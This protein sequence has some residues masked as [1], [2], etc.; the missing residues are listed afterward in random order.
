MKRNPSLTPLAVL[1]LGA[2]CHC[3]HTSSPGIIEAARNLPGRGSVQ[4]S[5]AEIPRAPVPAQ[6]SATSA[7]GGAV[8]ISVGAPVATDAALHPL[9]LGVISGPD[10]AASV[11]RGAD[12][13]EGY[14]QIGVVSVRNND[15]YDDRLDFAGILDC[16]AATAP[17][18]DGCDPAKDSSYRW[19]ASDRQY[20]SYLDG[21][22][23]PFLRLG[24]E[25]QNPSR[26]HA[27]ASPKNRQQEDALVEAARRITARYK[28]W[29]AHPRAFEYLDIWTEFPGQHFWSGNPAAF[30]P[31]WIRMYQALDA[32][33]PE[34][35]IGG[36]GFAMP[37]TMQ[38]L[39]GR[40]GTLAEQ[41]LS[42][43]YS[44]K[45][46]PDWFGWHIFSSSPQEYARAAA[47][48]QDL[49]DGRG[50]FAHV[51]WAGS[52]FFRGTEVIVDAYGLGA[53]DPT[54]HSRVGRPPDE[55][56]AALLTA[57]WI[58]LQY[59]DVKGAFYYRGNDQ[60][61]AR[62]AG[63]LSGLFTFDG[64][65]KKSAE[66][67]ALWSRITRGYPALLSTSLPVDGATQTVWALAARNPS[68]A[69]AL[70]V[71]NTADSPVTIQVG[72]KGLSGT[73]AVRVYRVD[74]SHDGTTASTA[75]PA[76]IALAANG[77]ALIEL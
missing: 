30:A 73:G 25:W 77:V 53:R 26:P 39:Q 51:P 44:S 29:P 19:E 3:T 52:G 41:F 75:D 16:G 4:A 18:W 59:A 72:A 56:K 34:L 55:E 8:S 15:Y 66:A 9:M 57:G 45:I 49:L 20:Q 14:Q 22:F 40:R 10:P 38:V 76:G 63:G 67:F 32:E 1:L 61:Q 70:L 12:L 42:A 28:S 71:A 50:A 27:F 33:H 74:A 36:P 64:Q 47:N 37:Q 17:S 31:F 21:G 48:Y 43:L 58:A 35:K 46:Q 60:G 65:K 7:S 13:T 11:A 69:V 68:G 5:A 2:G 24:D 62:G 6:V 23:I 54:D